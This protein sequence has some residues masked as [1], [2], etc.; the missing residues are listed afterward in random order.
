MWVYVTV[1]RDEGERER[2]TDK[3]IPGQEGGALA[4]VHFRQEHS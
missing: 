3:K 2:E 4:L 1:L